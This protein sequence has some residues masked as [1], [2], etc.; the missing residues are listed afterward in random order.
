VD[1]AL[2]IREEL[3]LFWKSEIV[4]ENDGKSFFGYFKAA[5][6]KSLAYSRCSEN[7]RPERIEELYL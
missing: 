2:E 4:I 3:N 5:L 1:K 7:L 6:S